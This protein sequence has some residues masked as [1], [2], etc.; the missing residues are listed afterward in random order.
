[1]DDDGD[2][3][4]YD[5]RA[6]SSPQEIAVGNGTSVSCPTVR[7]CAA[8]GSIDNVVTYGGRAWSSPHHADFVG[9]VGGLT[10][11]SCP[12]ASFCEVVSNS[13]VLIYSVSATS[14]TAL[15]LS[16]AKVIYGTEQ[17]EH[18]SVTVSPEFASS[19]PTGLVT[20]K[21]SMSTVCVIR[22]T[23]DKGSCTLSANK[24][25]PG[26]YHLVATYGGSTDFGISGSAMKT[27]TVT[28]ATSKTALKLAVVKVTYGDE[29][30][31]RLLVTVSPEF[32]SSTPT[33]TVTVKES[34]M[35]LCAINLSSGRGEFTLASKKLVVG[36]YG[37]VAA[38]SGSSV[39]L[40]S[41]SARESLTVAK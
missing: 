8:V 6:W 41:V 39:F 35:T 13:D 15:K 9:E 17:V 25:P 2:A 1:M 28:R 24:L 38:Y 27:L 11:V 3:L 4:T 18:V 31:E 23:S 32:A 19:T 26:I 36:S 14:I 12:T 5:G 7:F 20:V 40:G 16:A 29:Q 22:L 37:L 34:T 21:E 33:G 10:S 30:V